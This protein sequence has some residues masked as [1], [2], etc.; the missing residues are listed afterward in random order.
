MMKA[1]I[2]RGCLVTRDENALF[3]YE[4]YITSNTYICALL[5]NLSVDSLTIVHK[6][7]IILFT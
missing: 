7:D 6:V 1:R 3:K 4:L 5:I 2:L